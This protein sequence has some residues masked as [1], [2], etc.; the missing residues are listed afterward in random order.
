MYETFKKLLEEHNTTAYQVSKAT[1]IAP[2]CFSDW[3]S[4]KYKPKFDKLCKIADY[5]GVNVNIFAS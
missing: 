3:K 2:T 4:G 5:F 1:G